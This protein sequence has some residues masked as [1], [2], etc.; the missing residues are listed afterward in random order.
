MKEK[1]KLLIGLCT[2]LLIIGSVFLVNS[3]NALNNAEKV[4]DYVEPIIRESCSNLTYLE[5]LRCD[6]RVLK[7]TTNNIEKNVALRYQLEAKASQNILFAILI[8]I[9]S[10]VGLYY[11]NFKYEK[12]G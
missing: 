5:K 8:I 2:F 9:C 3:I 4:A 7:D 6:L 11:F 12:G 1:P 10:T